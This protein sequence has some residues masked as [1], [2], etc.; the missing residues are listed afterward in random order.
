MEVEF[1]ALYKTL[2]KLRKSFSTCKKRIKDLLKIIKLF[3]NF[4]LLKMEKDVFEFSR[5]VNRKQRQNEKYSLRNNNK[6]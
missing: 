4:I 6:H 1:R 2:S 3:E 5:N